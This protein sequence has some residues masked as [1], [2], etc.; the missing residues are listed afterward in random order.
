M[1]ALDP[2][3]A[4]VSAELIVRLADGTRITTRYEPEPGGHLKVELKQEQPDEY[5]DFLAMLR[6]GKGGIYLPPRQRV[7]HRVAVEQVG[8]YTIEHLVPARPRQ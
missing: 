6:A 7:T 5:E 2:V 8:S 3:P 4:P 1:S